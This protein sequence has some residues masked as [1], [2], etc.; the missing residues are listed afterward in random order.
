MSALTR[1][2]HGVE[3]DRPEAERYADESDRAAAI[4]AAIQADAIALHRAREARVRAT[5][6]PGR[7]TNCGEACAPLAVYCDTA[8]RAD[9]E[10]RL[11]ARQRS[12]S[13]W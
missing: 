13:A 8:C 3:V 9:H 1:G 5:Q 7:C 12:G 10:R 2:T 11:S 6:T 4:D